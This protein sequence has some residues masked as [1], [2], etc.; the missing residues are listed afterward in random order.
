MSAIPSKATALLDGVPLRNAKAPLRGG[1]TRLQKLNPAAGEVLDDARKD[2]H[3]EAKQIADILDI[4]ESLVHRALKS[5]AGLSF[6]RLWDL[7]DEF[8]MALLV[9]IAK[10]RNLATVRT[11]IEVNERRTA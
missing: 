3:L 11:T 9:A 2:A 7:P 1:E 5:V 6:H 8:W 4:S 10:K